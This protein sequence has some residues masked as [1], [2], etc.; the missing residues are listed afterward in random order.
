MAI[1]LWKP[2]RFL[3]T[4]QSGPRSGLGSLSI[5]EANWL[6]GQVTS[7]SDALTWS[8]H[9]V[10]KYRRLLKPPRPLGKWSAGRHVLHVVSYEANS[11]LPA[12]HLW[13][14]EQQNVASHPSLQPFASGESIEEL[15][16]HIQVIHNRRRDLLEGM[17]SSLWTEVRET[18]WGL[19]SL[20]WVIAKTYQHMTEHIA[21]ILRIALFWDIVSGFEEGTRVNN[22]EL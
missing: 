4:K 8:F 17:E 9:Q 15:V 6:L 19:V 16:D 12:L 10:P 20:G 14:G 5:S 7:S 2:G 3:V 1:E 22:Q 11:A 21:S 13:L 18:E